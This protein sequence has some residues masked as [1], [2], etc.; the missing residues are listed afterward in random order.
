[1]AKSVEVIPAAKEQWATKEILRTAAYC[2]VS[3]IREGQMGSLAAQQ[4][5]FTSMIEM[6]PT[7]SIAK[8]FVD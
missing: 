4:Q 5:F 1:M 3:T 8:I 2:Q 6:H 7:I